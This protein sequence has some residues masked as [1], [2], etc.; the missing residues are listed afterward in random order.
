MTD[1][2]PKI[3]RVS[4]SGVFFCYIPGLSMECGLTGSGP[5]LWERFCWLEIFPA[6]SMNFVI[7]TRLYGALQLQ[8]KTA[9][10][11]QCVA[12]KNRTN[13]AEITQI[14]VN[15]FSYGPAS[16]FLEQGIS[17][18]FCQNHLLAEV[19][20]IITA[21]WKGEPT[22]YL[23]EAEPTLQ[24]VCTTKSKLANTKKTG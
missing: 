24:K 23:A 19:V 16:E 12:T 1:K 2:H 7:L 13:Q 11:T 20:L 9:G 17:L 22:P 8:S 21:S 10:F 5:S 14:I 18:R 15:S 4:Q 3:G 6:T